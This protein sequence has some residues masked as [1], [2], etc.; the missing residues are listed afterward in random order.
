M[1]IEQHI[2]GDIVVLAI[3]GDITMNDAGGGGVRMAEKVRNELQQGHS[4][5]VTRLLTVFECFDRESE[6]LASFGQ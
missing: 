5:I 4:R 2:V 6:A 3:M 1:N